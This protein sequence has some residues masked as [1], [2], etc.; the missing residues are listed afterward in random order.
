MVAHDFSRFGLATGQPDVIAPLDAFDRIT[1]MISCPT[2]VPFFKGVRPSY[3]WRSLPQIPLVVTRSK[4]SVGAFKVG[5]ARGDTAI[6]SL[7][8]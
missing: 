8:S 4:A 5:L 6:F 7:L 2:T 1:P 3:M